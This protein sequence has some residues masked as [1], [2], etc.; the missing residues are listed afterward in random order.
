VG[1]VD[2]REPIPMRVGERLGSTV[3]WQSWLALRISPSRTAE[4]Y[5]TY[6]SCAMLQLIHLPKD[7]IFA[8]P[9]LLDESP[10]LRNSVSIPQNRLILTLANLLILPHQPN[11]HRPSPRRSSHTKASARRHGHDISRLVRLGPHVRRPD[12]RCD[13]QAVDDC[14]RTRLLLFCL[15]ACG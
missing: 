2:A 10:L 13:G 6:K 12:E 11:A 8:A 9:T 1:C 14:Q 4:S 7:L 15:R 3:F 5:D